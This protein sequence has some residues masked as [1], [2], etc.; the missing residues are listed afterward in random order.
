[1]MISLGLE[2]LDKWLVEAESTMGA[3]NRQ[4]F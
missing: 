2:S 1:M 3:N 4:I